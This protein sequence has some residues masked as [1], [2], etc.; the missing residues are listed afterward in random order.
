MLLRTII[1]WSLSA[2]V[3]VQACVLCKASDILCRWKHLTCNQMFYFSLHRKVGCT[4]SGFYETSIVCYINVTK[5]PQATVSTKIP[6]W[7]AVYY[8]TIHRTMTDIPVKELGRIS[9]LHQ[10]EIGISQVLKCWADLFK[11]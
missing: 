8:Y 11:F 10:S 7:L 4:M 6:C 5:C 2:R 9:H 3:Q 1:G